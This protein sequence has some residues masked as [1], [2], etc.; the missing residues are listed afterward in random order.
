MITTKC[1][2]S[3]KWNQ[4]YYLC[5]MENQRTESKPPGRG[6]MS[7]GAWDLGEAKDHEPRYQTLVTAERTGNALPTFSNESSQ[8]RPSAK[9]E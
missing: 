5:E 4:V 1:K 2:L 6:V 9:L 3:F 7:T 8:Q